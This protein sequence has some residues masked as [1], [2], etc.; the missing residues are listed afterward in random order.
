MTMGF[1][2]CEKKTKFARKDS[3]MNEVELFSAD[4]S[5]QL[6]RQLADGGIRAG[7]PSPAQDYLEK[8]IDLNRDLIANPAATFYGR[9]VGDSMIDANVHEGDL[10]V[11]DKSLDAKDGDLVV[12]YLDG[13]FTLKNLDL[14]QKAKDIIMLRPA[15]PAYPVITVTDESDFRIWGVVTYVIHKTH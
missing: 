6:E 3:N 5:T 7:F 1:G 12:A 4:M 11:I 14:S 9:V 10:L 2:K 15:N 8:S 13:E